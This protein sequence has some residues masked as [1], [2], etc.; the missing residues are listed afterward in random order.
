MAEGFDPGFLFDDPGD[1]YV[2]GYDPDYDFELLDDVQDE[3]L[4]KWGDKD[5]F[6]I[7]PEEETSFIDNLP[8]VPGTFQFL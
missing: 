4:I 8:D 7:P 6:L 5:G 1:A 2:P 3:A